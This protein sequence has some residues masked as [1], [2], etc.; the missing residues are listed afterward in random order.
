LL[1]TTVT[2]YIPATHALYRS[3]LLHLAALHKKPDCFSMLLTH[4][5]ATD[6][7]AIIPA[8]MVCNSDAVAVLLDSVSPSAFAITGWAAMVA[9]AYG[10]NASVMALLLER[11]VSCSGVIDSETQ[12]TVLHIAAACAG[13]ECVALLLRQGLDPNVRTVEGQTLL[14]MINYGGSASPASA[15]L[16]AGLASTREQQRDTALLLLQHGAVLSSR[17]RPITDTDGTYAEAQQLYIEW[18]RQGQAVRDATLSVHVQR[19]HSTAVT[20]S[21]VVTSSITTATHNDVTA[22]ATAAAAAVRVQLGNADTGERGSRVYTINTAELAQL[23][24]A[25][26][27][28]GVSI[29]SSLLVPPAGWA[30]TTTTTSSVISGNTATDGVK[31]LSYNGKCIACYCC[32]LHSVSSVRN[33]ASFDARCILHCYICRVLSSHYKQANSRA[34]CIYITV[35]WWSL[36]VAI[37]TRLALTVS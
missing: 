30:D 10:R 32:V 35:Y 12:M 1:L 17:A 29:L 11:G 22:T 4:G 25:R 34:A 7:S 5:V 15:Q 20:A 27:E 13:V 9:G 6:H 26:G 2:A 8:C 3:T 28:A 36:Q 31:L 16:P 21:D 24:A 18:L 37:L 14:D 33:H 23:H 19:T